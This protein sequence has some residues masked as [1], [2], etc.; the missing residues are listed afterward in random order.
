MA[1]C[2]WRAQKNEGLEV[3]KDKVTL[4]GIWAVGDVELKR[5]QSAITAKSGEPHLIARP[6][7]FYYHGD[8]ITLEA[9]ALI[10]WWTKANDDYYRLKAKWV[11]NDLFWLPPLGGW[12][13]LATFQ[14][15]IFEM[16][17]DSWLKW[18]FD[19]VPNS[20]ATPEHQ[21][22]LK[23]RELWKYSEVPD[24]MARNAGRVAHPVRVWK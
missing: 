17:T 7:A 12:D 18:R 20:K 13:K 15:G 24:G 19:H 8:S 1:V 9:I 11:G 5:V 22:L 4:I 2:V 21:P 16:S 10:P 23:L 6:G 3:P 14:D